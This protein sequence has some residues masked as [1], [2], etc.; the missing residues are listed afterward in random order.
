M[1]VLADGAAKQGGAGVRC[2]RPAD[3]VAAKTG[4][5]SIP[6]AGPRT[7]RGIV[8]GWADKAKNA[9]EKLRGQAKEK[10]GQASGDQG[11]QAEGQGQQATADLKQAAEKVKDAF[12]K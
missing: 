4:P 1:Y 6:G 12:R 9:A 7:K 5:V 11:Q 3:R 8:M 10:A 2:G